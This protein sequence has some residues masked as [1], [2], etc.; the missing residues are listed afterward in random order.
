MT[1]TKTKLGHSQEEADMSE[2]TE[3]TRR[4][5]QGCR[6]RKGSRVKIGA[7][8]D[9]RLWSSINILNDPNKQRT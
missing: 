9:K 4:K 7:L 2:S 8:K 5:E 3:G 6:Q 1:D